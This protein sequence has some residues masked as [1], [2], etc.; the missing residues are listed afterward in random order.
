VVFERSARSFDLLSVLLDAAGDVVITDA[1]FAAVWP[2]VIVEDNTV[3]VHT[4]TDVL[5][6]S[7]PQR[8]ITTASPTFA[9]L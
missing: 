3:Q 2:N 1:L 4:L 5:V 8:T 9:G 6:T 7:P